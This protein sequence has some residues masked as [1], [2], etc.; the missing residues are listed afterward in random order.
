MLSVIILAA[1]KGT[2]MGGDVPKVLRKVGDLTMLEH[3]VKTAKKISEKV[4]IVVSKENKEDINKLDLDVDYSTQEHLNGTASAVISAKEKYLNS[5]ILVLLGDVPLLKSET[6]QNIVTENKN[7]ILGFQHTDNNNKFGRIVLKSNYVDRIVEY[8][9]ATEDERN[10]KIVNSGILFLKKEYTYLLDVIDNKNS[11][12]EYYLTDIVKIC[13]LNNIQMN[14]Y[15]ADI[16]E[17]LG[18]NTPEDLAIIN[19]LI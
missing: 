6:L 19:S 10:I 3:V 15:E 11:K 17:C 13:N 1:G 9:E 7:C 4:I 12:G 18:A 5:D 2:R 8:S 16:K 14:Y